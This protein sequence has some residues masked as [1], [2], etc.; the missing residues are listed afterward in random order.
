LGG[1]IGLGFTS[2]AAAVDG[3]RGSGVAEVGACP[4]WATADGDFCCDSFKSQ[5]AMGPRQLTVKIGFFLDGDSW[6]RRGRRQGFH[7]GSR[8]FFAIYLFG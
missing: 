4:R 6:R 8:G 1:R 2:A 5:G 7:E 3:E